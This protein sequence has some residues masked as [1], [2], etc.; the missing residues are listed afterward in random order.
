MENIEV[1]D[2]GHVQLV[3]Y[4]GSDLTVVNAARV[5]FANE[6]HFDIDHGGMPCLST[7]DEK[8]INKV[9]SEVREDIKELCKK[10]PIYL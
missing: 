8:L 7:K 2:N 9:E 3:S 6:S 1:L 5:S 10:F 4:M